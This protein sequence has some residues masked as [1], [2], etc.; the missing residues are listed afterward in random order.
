MLADILLRSAPK[1]V[2]VQLLLSLEAE[3]LDNPD[4]IYEALQG[5]AQ[6]AGAKLERLTG[7]QAREDA[8]VDAAY[9]SGTGGA[10][11][12][13]AG[14]VQKKRGGKRAGT[15]CARCGCK[16][17]HPDP[18]MCW[19]IGKTCNKCGKANH[20]AA[21][22]R[23]EREAGAGGSS[24]SGGGRR[25][26][27]A[28]GDDGEKAHY[29]SVVWMTTNDRP[30]GGN[31][32]A[33]DPQRM[34]VDTCASETVLPEHAAEGRLESFD[35]RPVK[36]ETTDGGHFMAKGRAVVRLP[37]LL[38]NGT[39]TTIR[40]PANLTAAKHVPCLLKPKEAKLVEDP[41]ESWVVVTDADGVDWT[42]QVDSPMGGARRLPYLLVQGPLR[43]ADPSRGPQTCWATMNA[44]DIGGMH[45]RLLDACPERVHGTMKEQGSSVTLAQV[46]EAIG[47][48]GLCQRRNAVYRTPPRSQERRARASAFNDVVSWDY[49][50]MHDRGPKGERHISMLTDVRT[51]TWHLKA[52]KTKSEGTTHLLEWIDIYGPMKALRSDNAPELKSKEVEDLCAANNI[53]MPPSPPYSSETNGIVESAIKQYRALARTAIQRLELPPSHWAPLSKGIAELHNATHS[54]TLGS[55][56][57]KA[58]VG[59]AP[60]TTLLLGDVAVTKLP[61]PKTAP[62]TLELPGTEVLYLGKVNAQTAIVRSGGQLLNVHP[63]NLQPVR[64]GTLQV[65]KD[66]YKRHEHRGPMTRSAH[67]QEAERPMGGAQPTAGG[68]ELLIDLAT[69]GSKQL[70]DSSSEDGEICPLTPPPGHAEGVDNAD[71]ASAARAPQPADGRVLVAGSR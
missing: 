26:S 60:D 19:A 8:A 66:R 24:A 25:G 64:R 53:L 47:N 45:A 52:L 33:H 50:Y 35:R 29:C 55:S 41:K 4:E 13:T 20:F 5:L 6:R 18:A 51:M 42:L 21:V 7:Q 49:G 68:T 46:K 37:L 11:P 39:T 14:P 16:Q 32:P 22:C 57:H 62:K 9:Y 28:T 23:S 71:D 30:E 70:D 48:C 12:R 31:G 65:W 58:R 56:P 36:Y 1:Q 69:M 10:P 17:G 38:T 27:A 63:I 3:Q 15:A 61:A 44:E 67:R 43:T 34:Y 2:Q 59:T 40:L 54:G